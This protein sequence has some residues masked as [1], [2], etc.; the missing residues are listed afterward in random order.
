VDS[1]VRTWFAVTQDRSNAPRRELA[2]LHSGLE[3][4]VHREQPGEQPSSIVAT[5]RSTS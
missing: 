4:V 3:P 2:G 5:T 1:A